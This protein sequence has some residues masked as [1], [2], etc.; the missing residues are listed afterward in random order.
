LIDLAVIDESG[1]PRAAGETGE[2]VMRGATVTA[3]YPDNEEANQ[4]AFRDGWFRSGDLGY[5]D[6]DGFVFVTGRIK[7]II[8]RGGEKITPLEVDAVLLRHPAVEEAATFGVPHA[9]LGEE[10]AAVVV[11]ARGSQAH[12]REIRAFAAE[13]LPPQKTPRQVLIAGEIPKSPAGK[14]IR[15][16]LAAAL[17]LK[18]GGEGPRS[19]YV[20]ASTPIERTLVE[21]WTEVLGLDRVGTTENLF[22]LGGN[23]LT[24]MQIAARISDALEIDLPVSV[25]FEH[26]TVAELARVI[27]PAKVLSA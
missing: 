22:Q 2:I 16:D 3:G 13:H 6:E 1:R 23:S 4:Q 5:V 25:F 7:E 26:P 18:F 27:E 10:V 24:A 15:R 11:L 17:G 20:E 8:N 19:S 9:T 14:V 21:I 12:A